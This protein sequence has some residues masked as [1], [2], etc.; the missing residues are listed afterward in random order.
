MGWLDF[1]KEKKSEIQMGIHPLEHESD[2]FKYLYCFGLATA[3]CQNEQLY[4]EVR[5]IFEIIIDLLG[6]HEN[7][8]T[9][10]LE[11]VEKD[12]DYR[13][14]QVFDAI[15]TKEKRYCFLWFGESAY[16]CTCRLFSF[17]CTQ[18]SRKRLRRM[19]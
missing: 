3:F 16:L 18:K 2:E 8:K 6:M 12:F 9:R 10:I 13:I 11:D 5:F 15:D 7:Y 4:K 17:L 14:D 1:L 19:L